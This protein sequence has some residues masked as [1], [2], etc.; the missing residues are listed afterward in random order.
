MT[1]RM[2]SLHTRIIVV[3]MTCALALMVG[4]HADDEAR[5]AAV[6]KLVDTGEIRRAAEEASAW[7]LDDPGDIEAL[8]AC[9]DLA[10]RAGLLRAAEDALRSLLFFEPNV[11]DT[12]VELGDVF[13]AQGRYEEA[14]ERYQEA[15][16]LN[17]SFTPA[18]VGVARL[19]RYTSDVPADVLSAAEVAVSVGAG[20]AGAVTALAVA[21]SDAGRREQALELFRKAL[22]LD[23]AYAPAWYELGL[24]HATAGDAEQAREAWTRYV[25]LEPET[26]EA[27]KL[28]H[29]LVIGGGEMFNDRSWYAC[30]SPDGT[31]IA[32]RARGKGGWGIYLTPADAP[33]QERLLWATESNIQSL[34]WSP[35]G[36][37]LLLRIY[38]KITVEKDGK[39][40]E[41]WTYQLMLL[42]V[43]GET[44]PPLVMQDR[45]MGDPC[46]NPLTGKIVARMYIRKV[47]YVLQS[48]DPATGAA[49][50]IAG[51]DKTQPKYT[52]RWCTD[53]TQAAFVS[54]TVMQP[55][56][57]YSYRIFSGPGNDLSKAAVI[58]ETTDMPRA[59]RFTPDGSVVLFSKPQ[60]AGQT[61]RYPI[62]AVPAD[63]S[64]EPCLVD[65]LAGSNIAP[66]VSPDGR[67]ML[68]GR[69]YGL[70][71]LDLTGLRGE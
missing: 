14:R 16:H 47:G 28:R 62:W 27:W 66:E 64:R 48:I 5:S 18:F 55:D 43:E 30:Y 35:D 42:P 54:R 19:E 38:A 26:A 17:D 53:G 50:E 10:P 34:A 46:W 31:Q 52:P 9:A 69:G 8:R 71:R 36:K 59:V 67:Y 24:V 20:S 51:V 29:N 37:A 56:G 15:I 61:T 32:Y 11:P 68:S 60:T 4:A 33:D 65:A 40:S 21:K 22:A 13:A 45:W 44:Q 3:T 1:L 70:W 58:Y 23:D 49:K 41:Q 63:G 7:A 25:A 39:S 2:N 57:T 6:Q 12:L